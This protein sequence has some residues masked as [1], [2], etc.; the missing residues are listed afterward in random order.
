VD[1]FALRREKLIA[2]IPD[3]IEFLALSNPVSVTYLTGFTGDSSWLLLSPHRALLVSD[4]RYEVQIAEECASLETHIRPPD[5]TIITA[6]AEVIAKLKP[7]SVG[8]EGTHL[9]CADAERLG[10]L[11]KSVVW[12][13][14]GGL[15][16]TLRRV[17]DAAELAE[18]RAAVRMAERAHAMF[19]AM[20]QA[21]DTE[22]EL[23]AAMDGYLRRAGATGNSF[24]PIVAVGDRSALPH[25]KPCDRRVEE[26]PFLLLDW[27]AT[28]RLY[29]SDITR[30]LL[31]DHLLGA[32]GK[33]R[34]E[35]ESRL[36][37]L[38][39][40][41]LRAQEIAIAAIRPGV[42]ASDVDAAVRAYLETEG[43]N[44]KF[45]H[46]L[47]HG[48]GLQ[49]HEAPFMRA[50]STDVLEAGMVMTVEPGI[51]FPGWGGIRIEDDVWVTPDGCEILTSVPKSVDAVFGI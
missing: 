44:D 27:G 12:T 19:V 4:G 42:N 10:G 33:P 34:G 6:I 20:L 31:T 24:P 8:L 16:E 37:K 25:G 5:R 26:S 18:I 36:R 9:T 22:M 43:V 30:I 49:I 47:G 23:A 51:Y 46:G 1:S 13:N 45:N 7:G 32:S 48:I 38:Y 15:V 28:G 41:V 39:T 29:K 50:N 40:V 14:T 17:K 11:A 2:L 35:I 3:G 21:G